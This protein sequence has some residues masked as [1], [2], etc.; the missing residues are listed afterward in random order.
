MYVCVYLRGVLYVCACV[1]MF[2]ASLYIPIHV[3]CLMCACLYPRPYVLSI[4]VCD[5]VFWFIDVYMYLGNR[6]ACSGKAEE[7]V[8][9][10][11]VEDPPPPEKRKR[12]RISWDD[13][14]DDESESL[15]DDS[16][17]NPTTVELE[18]DEQKSMIT[19]AYDMEIKEV[20]SSRVDLQACKLEYSIVSP[21]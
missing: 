13:D 19:S 21:K 12:R 17:S 7:R 2:R 6:Y 14:E 18:V 20:G 4:F 5:C 10:V 3:I 8:T 15:P 1:Y 9:Q 16:R 11:A